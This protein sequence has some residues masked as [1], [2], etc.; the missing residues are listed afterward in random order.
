MKKRKIAISNHE[1]TT[2]IAALMAYKGDG[3]E[4]FIGLAS[5]VNSL[6]ID[7]DPTNNGPEVAILRAKP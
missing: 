2:I 3:T 6:F 7:A 5:H 1:R 4:S